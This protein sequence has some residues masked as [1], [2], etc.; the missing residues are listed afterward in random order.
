MAETDTAQTGN[1]TDASRVAVAEAQ[2]PA[3]A[4]SPDGQEGQGIAAVDFS[5]GTYFKW[6]GRAG[7]ITDVRYDTV[8]FVYDDDAN[9][10]WVTDR[11]RLSHAHD[12][13]EFEFAPRPEAY[14][15]ERLR[16]GER[17]DYHDYVWL[18]IRKGMG[19]KKKRPRSIAIVN[20]D[21]CTGCNACI[22]VCPTDCIEEVDVAYAGLEGIGHFCEVRLKDCIGCVQCVHICPWEAIDMVETE[23]V[24]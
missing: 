20:P 6:K 19:V 14:R 13:G 1:I 23:R 11:Y 17:V 22:E 24:E 8:R 5:P 10:T 12:E 9:Q 2:T 15:P 21:Y 7:R 4:A 3:E 18:E 16:G